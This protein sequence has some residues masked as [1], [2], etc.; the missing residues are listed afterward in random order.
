[1]DV[2]TPSIDLHA[3]DNVLTTAEPGRLGKIRVHRSGKTV[4][5]LEADDG[6]P[7]VSFSTRDFHAFFVIIDLL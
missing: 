2:S 7:M 5:V 3:F 1:M 6:Q 4:L